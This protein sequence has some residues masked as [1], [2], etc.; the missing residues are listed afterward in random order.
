MKVLLVVVDGLAYHLMERFIDQLPTIQEMAEEGVY[1][2]LESTFPSITPVALAS[3]FTGVSPKVHG[4]VAPRIF[5][6]GRKI[7]SSISAFSSSSLMVDPIWATLGRKGYKV[8]ITSAPQALP[9]KWKL[10]NVILFDPY[11]AKVKRCS[12]GTLLKEGENEFIGKKWSVK[13]EDQIYL[14]GV[15]GQEFKVEMGSWIGPL[16]VNGKC[17]EEELKASIFLHATPRGV[18]VTPPAFLNFKWGNNRDLLLEVWENVVKKVGMLLDGDYKGLNKGLITFDEYLKTAEL[19]FNF[20][21]EYSLY[22]L[23]RSDWDFGVTY[24]PI[25][26]NLQHLLYGVDDGKALEHIFQAY[27]MA[28][29]FLM[30]HRSLAENI[31]LCS[32]HGITKIKKRVYVNKILERLNVLKMDDGKINWGKT[33]AYYGGGGLIRINLK[34]REEAGVVYPKEYQKLVRYIVKNL[35]DLK[36]DD[37]ESIFTGIYMRDTPASD[38]QG[39]IELSIR[40]YY[41]LSSNV[42][43]ENEI[44]TVKPYSTSTGDHGF[45]R[46]EDLYGVILGIGPKIA[47]GKKIKAK[48]VDIA[49][50]ILK[51]MDVQGSKMEGRVLV[52]ALSNGGQE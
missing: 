43:H 13:V 34:D 15:E 10:D 44:D 5:V 24:L 25:V 41:S 8:V 31:F 11:K 7:Q 32:D 38:R 14:V 29:K 1:G 39:D 16:E 21:V 28:D 9:D 33:K 37:G 49:P 30:L 48:I 23:R 26:D 12:E 35:E 51:I 20:F 50:T 52:E 27:K 3:L 4:V 40:D 22:L 36:D 18:Y 46:K 2:P 19:S 47:R 45:Y 17:G 42:D 6:K